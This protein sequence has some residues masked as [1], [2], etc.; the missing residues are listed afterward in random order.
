M[1]TFSLLFWIGFKLSAPTWYFGLCV[2]GF[3]F[4]IIRFGCNM[5]ELGKK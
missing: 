4:N 5:F 3:T 2:F 1:I